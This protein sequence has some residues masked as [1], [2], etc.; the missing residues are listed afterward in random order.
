MTT[1]K[2]MT[3]TVHPESGV[4]HSSTAL[5]LD[6]LYLLMEPKKEGVSWEEEEVSPL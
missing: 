5:P 1:I 3:E 2:G 6:L 4:A